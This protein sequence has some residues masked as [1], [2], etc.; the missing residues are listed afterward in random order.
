MTSSSAAGDWGKARQVLRLPIPWTAPGHSAASSS[1][2]PALEFQLDT[3][4]HFTHRGTPGPRRA[5][6]ARDGQHLE[7]GENKHYMYKCSLKDATVGRQ[8]TKTKAIASERL[9]LAM[10]SIKRTRG[11]SSR[12]HKGRY[13]P[14]CQWRSFAAGPLFN[15][16]PHCMQS[17]CRLKGRG[18]QE[19]Q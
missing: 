7:A 18:G 15:P 11:F 13:S 16:P 2:R 1:R 8:K 6:L 10:G 14:E 5:G 3:S 17:S 4:Q 9:A 19:D 12:R